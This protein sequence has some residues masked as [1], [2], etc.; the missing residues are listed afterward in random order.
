MHKKIRINLLLFAIIYTTICYAQK[1]NFYWEQHA[2]IQVQ[3]GW[4]R[5]MIAEVGGN[6]VWERKKRSTGDFIHIN[7]P[8]NM[9]IAF[10]LLSGGYGFGAKNGMLG[11]QTGYN[12][13]HLGPPFLVGVQTAVHSD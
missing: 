2:N 3:A 8:D 13:Y 4:Q 12:Y 5:M 10:V 9:H 1:E 11:L 6:Y 7:F